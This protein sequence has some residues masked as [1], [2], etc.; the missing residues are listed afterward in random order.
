MIGAWVVALIVALVI[1]SGPVAAQQVSDARVKELMAQA[2]VLAAQGGGGQD[3]ANAQAAPARPV[4]NL[5]VEDAVKMATDQNIDLSVARLNPQIQDLSLQSTFGF[6]R[7]TLTSTLQNNVATNAGTST[8]SGGS[9]IDTKQ[10]TYNGGISKALRWTGGTGSVTF[11]NTRTFSTNNTSNYNPNYQATFRA[12]LVQPLLQNFR[13]D[14]TRN[15][16]LTGQIARKLADVSLSATTLTTIANTRNAYWDLVFAVQAVE[17]AKQSLALAEK[18]V[19]DNKIRVEVGTMAPIDVVTAQSQAASA[20]QRLVSA[21]GTVRQNELTLKQ[22]IVSSTQ[23]PLWNSTINPTDRPTDVSAEPLNVEAAVRRALENRTDL[24]TARE[25][26]RSSEI[27][28]R[29][30][31]N[32]TLPSLNATAYYQSRGNGGPF[33]DRGDSITGIP[34]HI[35]PGGYMDALST[36]RKLN[37]PTWNVQLDFSYPLGRSAQDA[38]LARAKVQY[39]QSLTSLKSTELRVVTAVTNAALTVQ[40]SLEQVQAAGAARE[41]AQKALDA[42]Q[43]KFEVG[44]STNYNVIQAQNNLDSAKSSELQAILAYRKAL[45]NYELVQVTGS[46]GG[47]SAVGATGGGSSGGSSSPGGGA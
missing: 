47:S 4:V 30:Q 18:L 45:V 43:S 9:V 3:Q 11:N 28:L 32:Q 25:N 31:K 24:V 17:V 46:S 12:Q 35:V 40:S 13:I 20:K 8:I 33:L 41:L 26:L 22:L 2:K 16:I 44:M 21:Q 10:F 15:S 1:T 37:F 39:Q 19:E 23:D 36:L 14:T 34:A 38:N 6:Y 7:P 5:T 27:T 42:E 29:Y